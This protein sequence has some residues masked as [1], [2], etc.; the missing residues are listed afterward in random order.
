MNTVEIRKYSSNTYFDNSSLY[1]KITIEFLEEDGFPSYSEKFENKFDAFKVESSEFSININLLGDELSN[2]GYNIREFL[3]SNFTNKTV[4]VKVSMDTKI[5]GGILTQDNVNFND[6]YPENNYVKIT[7]IGFDN[8]LYDIAQK[9]P[10]QPVYNPYDNKFSVFINYRLFWHATN[11][12]MHFNIISNDLNWNL[13]LGFEPQ[14]IHE[15]WDLIVVNGRANDITNWDLFLDLLKYY[16]IIYRIEIKDDY[17]LDHFK[18][19][20]QLTFRSEP[21]ISEIVEIETTDNQNG[22]EIN[23]SVKKWQFFKLYHQKGDENIVWGTF[24]NEDV[25]ETVKGQAIPS[26]SGVY[27]GVCFKEQNEK[28]YRIQNQN[29]TYFNT[30][31]IPFDDVNEVEFSKYFDNLF[32]YAGGFIN[33]YYILISDLIEYTYDEAFA[34]RNYSFPALWTKP[35]YVITFY[36]GFSFWYL[37]S[38]SSNVYEITEDIWNNL[39]NEWKFLCEDVII[40]VYELTLSLIEKFD[41]K[42]FNRTIINGIT[43]ILYELSNLNFTE[44]EIKSYWKEKKELTDR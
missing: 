12:P 39:S 42:L 30:L 18:L 31:N 17:I 7:V 44:K 37:I 10:H 8:D 20:M 26:S 11:K 16:G 23:K 1:D 25:N 2:L 41:Y 36:P 21:F 29:H 19:E 27:I 5:I 40:K 9:K 15:V 43:Y 4:A 33:N 34:K 38:H 22:F 35:N 13:K 3:S 32:Y 28:E 14:L 6:S 24:F